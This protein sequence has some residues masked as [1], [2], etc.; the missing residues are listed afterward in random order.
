MANLST[1][2]LGLDLRNPLVVSASP[3][4]DDLAT[5]REL[6]AAGAAAVVIRSLFEEQI[7]QEGHAYHRLLDNWSESFTE[8]QSFFPEITEFRSGPGQYVDAVA[9]AKDALK[10]PVIGSLNGISRG[11]WIRYAR[12]LEDAGVDA[13]ELNVY[14]VA[15]DP[16][17]SSEAVESRYVELVAAVRDVVRIP[18]AVKV[19]PYFSSMANMA[20]R[21]VA[22]GADGLVLFNRFLQPDINLEQLSVE[23]SIR[24][25]TSSELRLPLRWIAILHGRVKASLAATTGVHTAEDAVKAL[26]AGADVTM[27]AS[28]LL[29][30]GPNHL[31]KILEGLS[32]WLDE[33][34]YDSVST[35]KGS[36]SQQACPDPAA[37]ERSNYVRGITG[38]H[39][40]RPTTR[41]A[42]RRPSPDRAPFRRLAEVATPYE[43][44]GAASDDIR[45]ALR[46][47]FFRRI[48]AASISRICEG[49]TNAQVPGPIG[50]TWRGDDA[51]VALVVS[52]W[53]RVSVI[54]GDGA[55]LP[56]GQVG[57]GDAFGIASL[58]T[59]HG[60]VQVEFMSPARLLLI[61][62]TRLVAEAKQTVEVAWAVA[63]ESSKAFDAL[64]AKLEPAEL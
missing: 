23:P 18:I 5:L 17:E 41:V 64:I 58:L 13:L 52:G 1:S 37:F 45:D 34:E 12:Y 19:G 54:T 3:L 47:S 30:H 26:L 42:S 16:N 29:R 32:D 27:M 28:A 20:Q 38:Y 14:F 8:A 6:E 40:D 31:S 9:A 46:G 50:F 59:D 55:Q 21:L 35:L 44:S 22:A 24:L 10:I 62:R 39:W 15:A 61:D 56:V 63:A 49:A 48:P 57:P 4:S 53:L 51:H 33:H 60:T 43:P 2:Y 36:L 11:G 25:S 7:E